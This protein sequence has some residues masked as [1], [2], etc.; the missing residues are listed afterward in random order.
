MRTMSRRSL[1][2]RAIVLGSA[3]G[4]APGLIARA[5]AAESCVQPDSEGLRESL[6]YTAVAADPVQ[7]CGKCAFFAPD[8]S[9]GACG[10]C[11]ILS[12]PADAAG[13]SDSWSPPS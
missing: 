4:L 11:A 1:M 7:S 9:T 5:G 12:G 6:N 2:G 13:H 10:A 8:A 3:V